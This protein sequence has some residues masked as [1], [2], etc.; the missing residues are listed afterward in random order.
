MLQSSIFVL[1]HSVNMYLMSR[2]SEILNNLEMEL[3]MLDM[4]EKI[5][6]E[7]NCFVIIL[8]DYYQEMVGNI[9]NRQLDSNPYFKVSTR[10]R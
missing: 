8:D 3:M 6:F 7:V 10:I 5:M 4:L 1:I 2:H 9:F